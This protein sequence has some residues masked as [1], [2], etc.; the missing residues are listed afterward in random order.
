MI[1]FDTVKKNL[2]DLTNHGLA[3][4]SQLKIRGTE[5]GIKSEPLKSQKG[6]DIVELEVHNK[7][8]SLHQ[9]TITAYKDA[10]TLEHQKAHRNLT[11]IELDSVEDAKH[12]FFDLPTDKPAIIFSDILDRRK[13]VLIETGKNAV[14]SLKNLTQF[15]E[16]N[17]LKHE[18]EYPDNR[19]HF[20]LIIA[21]VALVISILM[22]GL[23]FAQE[24]DSTFIGTLGTV[25]IIV[26][27]CT[28]SGIISSEC[29]RAFSHQADALRITS[30]AIFFLLGAS[31]IM[32]N[33]GIGHY[34]DAL[35]PDYPTVTI[36]ENTNSE[37][38]Q[39]EIQ[40]GIFQTPSEEENI[41]I[42]SERNSP[43]AEAITLLFRKFFLLNE[44]HSYTLTI[45]GMI[46]FGATMWLAW[47]SDDEYFQYGEKTRQYKRSIT[48]WNGEHEMI[49][50]DLKTQYNQIHENLQASRINFVEKRELILTNYD[51][52]STESINL[53]QKIKEV[54]IDS[55]KVYRTANQGV[56]PRL[57]PAPVHWN[58]NINLNWDELISFSTD[59]LCSQ[60]EALMMTQRR[61]EEIN[62]QITD[63][64]KIYQ[65]YIDQVAGFGPIIEKP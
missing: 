50:I 34:R 32:F 57:T 42:T 15:K 20:F 8:K 22:F 28:V 51:N 39:T 65:Q 17:D 59:F 23:L 58:E 30:K 38:S 35:D 36:S 63:L 45:L 6:F 27:F 48:K 44:L 43:S 53:I 21:G 9:D 55:I 26:T 64:E 62:H 54:C 11:K 40:D 49:V 1:E 19:A 5:R 16:K 4:H 31:A 29:L 52:F 25:S 41:G 3:S 2:D 33:L 60:E 10:V 24:S 56:R 61:D 13:S 18:A 7:M 37:N 47:K 12:E 14:D 46:L